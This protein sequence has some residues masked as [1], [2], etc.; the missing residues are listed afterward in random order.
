MFNAEQGIMKGQAIAYDGDPCCLKAE[1]E[2]T[3]NERL[4]RLLAKSNEIR[5]MAEIIAGRIVGP[6]NGSEGNNNE[7][8]KAPASAIRS[9][10]EINIQLDRTVDIL[11]RTLD[12]L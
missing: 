5:S 12:I 9:A 7:R 1:R 8:E 3:L 10:R 6:V 2:E 4:E 11:A